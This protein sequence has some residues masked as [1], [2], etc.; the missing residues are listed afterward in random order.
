MNNSVLQKINDYSIISKSINN[1]N[2]DY[3]P[4]NISPELLDNVY[5][6]N[7]DDNISYSEKEELLSNIMTPHKIDSELLT[8][9][10][11]FYKPTNKI[12]FNIDE[13]PKTILNNINKFGF[14]I[15]KYLDDDT[16]NLH[17]TSTPFFTF[18]D[19]TIVISNTINDTYHK[20]DN[21]I[22]HMNLI[23]KYLSRIYDNCSIDFNIK[24]DERYDISWL[25]I[26]I[27]Y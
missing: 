6:I 19:N 17:Y 12:K 15:K 16:F 21:I 2:N 14:L 3:L 7:N 25:L 11:L 27:N 22:N 10:L 24:N 18:D 9:E 26:I 20:N 1:D 8:Y 13:H 23:N 5:K 4:Y